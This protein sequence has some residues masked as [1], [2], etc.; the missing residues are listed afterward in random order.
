LNAGLQTKA[1]TVSYEGFLTISDFNG[2]PNQQF[3]FK[4]VDKKY[5]VRSVANGKLMSVS[6]DSLFAGSPVLFDNEGHQSENWSIDVSNKPEFNQGNTFS[7]RS[8]TFHSLDVPGGDYSN[9]KKIEVHGF[10][11]GANQI[12]IIKQV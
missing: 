10:H 11:G 1:L 8:W 5:K 3:T 6:S 2:A 7:I 9:G 12:W 4:N